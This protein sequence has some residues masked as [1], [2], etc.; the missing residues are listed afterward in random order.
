MY[1]LDTMFDALKLIFVTLF[2]GAVL[3]GVVALILQIPPIKS[4]VEKREAIQKEW[5]NKVNRCVV[6]MK[7]RKDC[8][9]IIYKN[10]I[11]MEN[12]RQA[13]TD[14]SII[15]AGIIGGSLAGRR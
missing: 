5:N 6:D 1:I 11:M 12:E 10:N 4:Y 7:S 3:I 9:L 2:V 14:A 15:N 8:S 13:N